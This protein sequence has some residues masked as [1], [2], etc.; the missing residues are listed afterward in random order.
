[1]QFSAINSC[2]SEK[3]DQEVPQVVALLCK[4]MVIE[5]IIVC[6]QCVAV[7]MTMY[8]FLLEVPL[9]SQQVDFSFGEDAAQIIRAHYVTIYRWPFSDISPHL[10]KIML[11]L[12]VC[13]SLN[14]CHAS[15][16]D[17]KSSK[18]KISKDRIPN[19]Q[20]CFVCT[21]DLSTQI[22]LEP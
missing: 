15:G 21:C 20:S 13:L 19:P 8:N 12:I 17:A 14:D 1:M 7:D 11:V 5:K 2:Y 4:Y 9:A 18:Q 10:T 16:T 22:V 3:E 6:R